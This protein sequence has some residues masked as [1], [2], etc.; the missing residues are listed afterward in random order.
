MTWP[1]SS[2]IVWL[3]ILGG[4]AVLLLGSGARRAARQ[5]DRARHVDRH[6]RAQLAAV[7]A[8]RLRLGGMQFVENVTWIAR[9]NAD[10]RA[11]RRR[12]L[13]AAR[14]ADD[15]PDAVRRR[16]GLA[17]HRDPARAVLR[18]VPDPR[19]ADGRHVRRDRRAAVLRVLGSDAG[20]D[21]HHHRRLGR[22]AARLRDGEVLPLYV[23]GLRVHARGPDLYVSAGRRLRDRVVPRPAPD[24]ERASPDLLRV[25]ARVRRQ[26]ADVP[27][28]H[29]ATRRARRGADGRLRD[30]RG[31]PAQ[32][33]R[34]RVHPLQLADHAR[35]EPGA[36]V[37][38]DRAVVDRGRLH[39]LRR[40]RAVR[41]EEADRLFVDRA[42]GLRDARL[43][44]DFRDDRCGTE[45]R[46][47]AA[48]A[49]GRHD[50]DA[51]ARP[52]LGCVVPMRRR[53]LRP[54]AQP[55]DR[56]LRRRHQHDAEVR[57]A[58]G[59]VRLGERRSAGHVGL[60]RR[61][62]RDPRHVPG[63]P[64]ARVPR[65]DDV[66]LG[67]GLHAVDDQTRRVRRSRERPRRR[68]HG[69]RARASSGC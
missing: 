4:I 64:V 44:R 49:P 61:V 5:A 29:V 19:R 17:S 6:V 11:R 3:P 63:R 8:F 31:D 67:R 60:R 10:Y 25:P 33:G 55:R 15:V 14:A 59:A 2:I 40:A 57:G 34:L 9:L 51:V 69:C 41:H 32:D 48:R 58:D 23:P 66:D 68:A 47:R 35:R 24:D 7:D 52:D 20:A 18:G 13:D 27:R 54:H 21:V 16:R 22:G 62:L 30:P 65:R 45:Q 26:G 56:R 38:H 39:R 50:A 46:R 36:R 37:A 1:C 43:L 53:A 12:Y 28:P 42:H